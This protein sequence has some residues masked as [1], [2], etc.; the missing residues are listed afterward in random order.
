MLHNTFLHEGAQVRR[1]T[2]LV[3]LLAWTVGGATL[4][5][6]AGLV[7]SETV[8]EVGPARIGGL[9]RQ[10]R[11][12]A[13]TRTGQLARLA[14]QAMTLDPVLSGLP[15]SALAV[16][17]RTVE[18]HGWVNNRAERARAGRV[19]RSVPGLESIINCILVHG[20]DD[21]RSPEDTTASA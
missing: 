10:R 20:E 15:L 17:A 1:G 19:A 13:P 6:A 3:G 12:P 8:G 21:F 11:R 2:S 5:L 4:G 14:R 7:L 9:V 16:S 18:L